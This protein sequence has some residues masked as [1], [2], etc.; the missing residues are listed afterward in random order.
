MNNLKKYRLTIALAVLLLVVMAG[1]GVYPT[2]EVKPTENPLPTEEVTEVPYTCLDFE[3]LVL[4]TQFSSGDIITT[5][6]VKV[7]VREFM[8]SNG[9]V[10]PSGFAKVENGGM[11][12]GSGNEL[13]I[14]NINLAFEF[15]STIQDFILL[16]GEYGGNLNIEIN[17]VFHNFEDF[18][19]I[20]GMN[21]GGVG[22][23]VQGGL[24]NDMGVLE[25]TGPI[26]VLMVGGQELFIDHE[27]EPRACIDFENLTAGTTYNVGDL[28]SSDGAIIEVRD[29]TWGNGTATPSGHSLVD[30]SGMAGGSGNEVNANNVNLYF[31]FG[32]LLTG[33]SLR[34]GA[35]GGNLNVEINGDF[36]NFNSM[37][38]IDGSVIGGVSVAVVHDGTS[39]LGTLTLDGE[40]ELFAFGGQELWIDHV[41]PTFKDQPV[42]SRCTDFDNYPDNTQMPQ[43]STIDG[44]T[45]TA[46][47]PNA[48]F[49]NDIA[50]G[51]HGLQ[52]ASTGLQIDLLAPAYKVTLTVGSY[53]PEPLKVTALDVNGSQVDDVSVPGDN[54]VHTITLSGQDINQIIISGGG[55]EG[56]L[57]DLCFYPG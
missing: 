11:A 22:I 48:P 29:F 8:W 18:K 52:F 44:L 46:L 38:D 56:I 16:F 26:D 28:F 34:Y 43:V 1:C 4:G 45:I 12:G 55:E 17:G 57:V 7:Y 40:I 20:D 25:L 41:C 32:G 27:C 23:S 47:G 6:G 15:P 2:E 51:V 14:N 50:A 3:D 10:T 33:L 5:A 13:A 31:D 9:T 53:T 24:G 54:S 42:F 37:T 39:G 21:L 36:V 19:D 30:N 49:V 35:H